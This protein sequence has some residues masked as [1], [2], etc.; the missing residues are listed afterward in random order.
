MPECPDAS[1]CAIASDLTFEV[2][3]PSNR[4][5]DQNEKRAIHASE[6]VSR[7]WF[8]DP[9]ARMLEGFALRDGQ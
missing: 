8:V 6:G 7:P 4:R 9:A 1:S 3:A 5:I 2:L